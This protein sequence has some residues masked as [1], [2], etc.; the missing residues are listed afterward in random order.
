M[1]LRLFFL[2]HPPPL[3]AADFQCLSEGSLCVNGGWKNS[4]EA[5]G[6]LG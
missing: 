3:S 2:L 4:L 6:C 5:R 1:S